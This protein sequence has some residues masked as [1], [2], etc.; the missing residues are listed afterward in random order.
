MNPLL[1]SAKELAKTQPDEALRLCNTVLNDH[2][3]D[4]DAQQA[5][6]ISAYIMMEA[7]RYGLAYNIYKRCAELRPN[8]SEIYS[9]MGMCLEDVRPLEA[10]ACFRKAQEL[11]PNNEHALANESLMWLRKTNPLRCIDLAEKA[12]LINPDLAVARHNRGLARLMLRDFAQ[13]WEDYA[14]TL[15][16]KH[17]E[18]RDYGVP[19]WDGVSPG[20]VLV[21]GEQGVGDEIMFASCLPDIQNEIVLDCDARLEKLF[22]R[23]FPNTAVYGTRFKSESPIMAEHPDIKWQCAIGQLP[24]YYRK[25]EAAF[26]GTPYLSPNQDYKTMFRG[27]F[28]TWKGKKVGLAWRGGLINTGERVRSL[29]LGDLEPILSDENTYISLEYKPVSYADIDKYNLKVFPKITGKGQEIDELAALISQLDYVITC[30]TTV[31]YIAGALGVPCYVLTPSEPGYRYHA[32]GDFPWYKSVRLHRQKHNESWL[33][34]VKR[35]VIDA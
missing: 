15:G 16:V 13:G 28:D 3:D 24:T 23:S 9:N 4:L 30:C 25:S 20:K 34:C 7:E 22:A 8:Q 26:P 31:V 10:I 2:L 32:H 12:L 19:D 29:A 5:L 21:Y 11:S 17:R 18:A 6:F 14:Q 33:E 27:L 1:V 35:L